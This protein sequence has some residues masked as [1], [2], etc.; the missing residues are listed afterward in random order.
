MSSTSSGYYGQQQQQ[1]LDQQGNGSMD[2]VSG[3]Y[4]GFVD[5]HGSYMS[6]GQGQGGQQQMLLALLANAV[7][8]QDS[9]AT[10]A[11]LAAV[12]AAAASGSGGGRNLGSSEVGAHLHEGSSGNML[13]T[14]SSA[15]QTHR[16]QLQEGT[17]TGTDCDL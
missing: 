8:Q 1:Q 13:G 7:Q 15:Q 4:I 16:Q 17:A 6:S 14:F 10:A 11:A 12:A 9:G 2:N 5:P 3:G